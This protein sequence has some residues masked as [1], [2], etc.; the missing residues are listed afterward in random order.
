MPSVEHRAAAL[1][2][3][4]AWPEPGSW[5]REAVTHLPRHAFAPEEV[6]WWDG[7]A[8][9][10]VNRAADPGRWADLVYAGPW[11]ATVTQV[12]G[13]RASSSLSC[14]SIVVDMLDALALAPG[15][16][17]LELGTGT[18]WNAALLGRRAGP[19]R[20]HSVEVDPAP[21]AR[22]RERLDAAG[23]AVHV[24]IG[25][26]A[27]GLPAAAPYDRVIATY[28]VERVPWA[29]VA[30]TRPGGRIVTPWGH[31][32]HVA[33]TVA[34]DG[35][36]A[37]GWVQGLA[38]FMPARG[39]EAP[40]RQQARAAHPAAERRPFTRDARRLGQD[41]HLRFGLRVALPDVQLVPHGDRVLAWAAD[42][43]WLELH[44]DGDRASATTGGPRDLAAELDRAW[45]E[46]SKL[47]EQPSLYDYG[48]T[49][50]EDGEQY[51]WYQDPQAGPR[52]PVAPGSG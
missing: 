16:R 2:D 18:G 26:G 30:Q 9:V 27:H 29:W 21:A 7:H 12:T 40:T 46:Y 43:S 36:S 47:D 49:V 20:V 48:M 1:A 34:D 45:D 37:T 11:A 6:W 5:I 15:H 33:L 44:P 42:G 8:Y 38:Q 52:W 41:A 39:T 31:L 3:E 19:W 4:I 25:D 17:V 13:G 32:G 24:H 51:L 14:P 10:P 28:A 35:R 50:R 22:A 23:A